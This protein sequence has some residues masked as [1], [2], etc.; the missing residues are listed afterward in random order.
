MP[1]DQPVQRALDV[2][3]VDEADHVL[4]DQARTPLI[5]SGNPVGNRR[6]VE[7]TRRVVKDLV[8]L[9]VA[10]VAELEAQET[11]EAS[12]EERDELL[13]RIM[14]ADPFSDFLKRK[15]ADS[16]QA[17]KRVTGQILDEDFR[18]DDD[19]LSASLYYVADQ[20][21]LTVLLTEQG[22][23]F[24]ESRLGTI[25]DTSALEQK[26][27]STENRLD[28][29]LEQTRS[30]GGKLRRRISR[31]HSQMNQ[32]HQALRAHVLLKRD[33]DYIV[34]DGNVVL[35]DELTGRTLTD[36]RYQQGLHNALEAKE[37]VRVHPE[38]E[39][40]AQISVQGFIS[41]YQQ[42]GGMTGTAMDAEDDFK[43]GY[44]LSVSRIAPSQPNKRTDHGPTLYHTR[45][46]KL[47]AIIAEVEMC[48]RVGRPVMVGTL[49]VEQSEEIS[50]LLTEKGIKHNLLNAVTNA[51]EAE[52]IKAA[53]AF[54]A[55]TIATNMAGRGTDILL[56]S[57]I[58][59][60]ILAANVELAQELLQEEST[61]IEFA[62]GTEAE[63]HLLLEALS[64]C[65]SATVLVDSTQGNTRRPVVR[66][67]NVAPGQPD[68][69]IGIKNLEF[70]L[71]LHVI[72]TELNQSRRIDLQLVGRSGRQ[73][74]FGSSRSIFSMEDQPLAFNTSKSTFVVDKVAGRTSEREFYT[75]AE[76]EKYVA[77][78]Q[79]SVERDDQV[80][81]GTSYEF[82]H[83]I[84]SQTLAYYRMRREFISSDSLIS[85][86]RD[87][88]KECAGH[89]VG[90]QLPITGVDKY[91]PRFARMAQE[92][93]A[94]Y[95]IDCYDLEGVGL[96]NLPGIVEERL[97][98]RLSQLQENLGDSKFARFARLIYL[99]A[100]DEL[101]KA[102]IGDAQ[103]LAL[104]IPLVAHSHKAAV[105]EFA[106]RCSD[107]YSQFRTETIDAF[108]SKLLTFPTDAIELQ[109]E[110]TGNMAL[111]DD[112]AEILV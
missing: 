84:E 88:V 106:I 29:T 87:F 43:R 46:D 70:G 95:G 92:L 108:P 44:H 91:Q 79:R 58:N 6:G 5:I 45:A 71:G 10:R 33:I 75:G 105:A 13:A 76:V 4:I 21:Y 73:G 64:Q 8:A 1:P 61:R 104:G 27:A 41:L 89:I 26:L 37:R 2:A 77:A 38:Y 3:I 68:R 107:R 49:T 48:Q 109:S 65:G 50:Q 103:E 83:V 54:G 90:R 36:S 102:H 57:G 40:L 12:P 20:R 52:T 47:A 110:I 112:I 59:D 67:S 81:R 14:L 19:K 80:Q 24:I 23:R 28:L 62:C 15:I 56:D 96:G 93:L 16:P 11:Q 94:D 82:T 111:T 22:Q 32:V 53:G 63:A 86:C 34:T 60:R 35:V 9:Q 55:V 25:F 99:Q 72:G 78:I 97:L 69:E 18:P 98:E 74:A 51:N 30:L 31:Q 17:Y 66:V 101:W 39:T 7:K 85:D 100:S 42:V